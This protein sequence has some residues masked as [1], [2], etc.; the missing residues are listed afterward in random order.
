VKRG[1]LNIKQTNADTFMLTVPYTHRTVMFKTGEITA[2]A[3]RD[4]VNVAW[5]LISF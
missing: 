3:T 5:Q 4:N 2:T 1:N